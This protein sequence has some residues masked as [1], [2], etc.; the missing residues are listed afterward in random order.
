MRRALSGLTVACLALVLAACGQDSGSDDG[1][2]TIGIAMPTKSSERWIA[3]GNNMVKEFAKRG[4][5]TDLQFGENVVENQV[6]QI[7]NMITKGVDVLV[8]AAID[9][10]SL[11]DA[12]QQAADNDIEVISYDRLIRGTEN[13]DVYATFDNFKVGVLQATYI[14]DKLGLASGKKGPFNVEL[15]AGSPDDNN[16]SFFFRGAMSVLQ[17][18]IDKGDIVVKSGQR[19]F[20]QVATL[21]WDGGK[22]QDRM[23]NLLSNSYSDDEV[24]AVLSPYDGHLDRHPVRTQE[25]RLRQR[26]QA[27]ADRHRSG[28]RT[29]VGQVDHRR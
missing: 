28:R 20:A 7:E 3:D 26:E 6:S 14:V 18:H 16:S 4:Y 12:L 8:V 10:S 2:T 1:T 15:F 23:D 24:D 11:S 25:R 19:K 21:R 27:V 13:V 29:G 5:D 22:A 9:G 17:P